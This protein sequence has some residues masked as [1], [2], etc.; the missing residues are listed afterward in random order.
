MHLLRDEDRR[1]VAAGPVGRVEAL[2]H[3]QSAVLFLRQDRAA[4]GTLQGVGE[5]VELAAPEIVRICVD[6]QQVA[7]PRLRDRE[8]ELL[9]QR[10][11]PGAARSRWRAMRR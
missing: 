2:V 7:E 10:V 6:V 5:T 4:D 8:R 9:E 3:G 1:R 11:A